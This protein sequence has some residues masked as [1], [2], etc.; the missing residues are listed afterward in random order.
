VLPLL[1]RTQDER[2]Q[3]LQGARVDKILKAEVVRKRDHAY[4]PKT[5]PDPK[6]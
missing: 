1:T 3:P 4:V 5:L 2:G 6:S